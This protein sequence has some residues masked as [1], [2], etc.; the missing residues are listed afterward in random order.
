MDGKKDTALAKAVET[1]VASASQPAEVESWVER[2]TAPLLTQNPE[3]AA[4]AVLTRTVRASVR[5]HWLAFLAS[6]SEPQREVILVQSGIEFAGELARRGH[7][8]TVLFR[9]YRLAQQAVWEYITSVI[10]ARTEPGLD[11]EGFL[12]LFWGRVSA[13][14]DSSIEASVDVFQ[15]ER[16]RALQGAAAQRLDAVRSVLAGS[17][18]DLRELSALLGGHPLSTF[19]TALLLHTEELERIPELS[20]AVTRLAQRIGARNPLVINPG[21]RNLWCW[22]ATRSTPD[23]PALRAETTWLEEHDVTVAVGT[24]LE[25]VEGFRHSH[26]EAQQAQSVAFR[27]HL[28]S[29]LTVY[30][31]VEVLALLAASPEASLRFVR[32]TLGGL[33]DD[34]EGP[35][36]LRQTFYALLCSGSVDEASRS[37]AIHKNTVRYRVGQAEALLGS[38][39]SWKPADV[40]LAVRYY[41][42][43]LA[44]PGN[45]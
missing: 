34:A 21:G 30:P 14:L 38:P 11:E 8:V 45:S 35:T 18:A 33:A 40:E 12:M 20:E 42:A 28:G 31:E 36:R 23:L 29:P 2:I 9:I 15:S 25:G 1:F 17:A 27:A 19:N 4:D 6:L 10:E 24:P 44:K 43:F 3:V 37:L 32:R 5:S 22:F 41:D 26:L 16:E 7:P 13:W 39:S